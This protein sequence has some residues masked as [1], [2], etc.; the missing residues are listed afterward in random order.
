MLNEIMELFGLAFSGMSDVFLKLF[1]ASGMTPLY[2]TMIFVVL[3]FKYF[4]APV[5]GKSSGSDTARGKKG[6]EE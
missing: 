5:I 4:L 1:N 6:R 2:L 3:V